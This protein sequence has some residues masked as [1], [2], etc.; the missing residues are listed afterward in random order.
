MCDMN[1]NEHIIEAILEVYDVVDLDLDL[2]WT[3]LAAKHNVDWIM[4]KYCK[5]SSYSPYM[6][7]IELKKGDEVSMYH[8]LGHW[9]GSEKRLN[10]LSI[11]KGRSSVKKPTFIREELMAELVSAALNLANGNDTLDGHIEYLNYFLSSKHVKHISKEVVRRA[12][13][14]VCFLQAC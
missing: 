12:K 9:T 4:R 11:R 2:H 10:R 5:N 3:M 8:E 13:K 7:W 14:A 1:K 6:D